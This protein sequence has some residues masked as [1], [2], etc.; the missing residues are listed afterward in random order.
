M[1]YFKANTLWCDS[2]YYLDQHTGEYKRKYMLILAIGPNGDDALAAVL[3]S[4]ANGLREDPAC[5]PGPPRA[6][7]YIGIPGSGL[8]KQ[9]WIDF[10]SVSD[11]DAFEFK[12]QVSNGRITPETLVL[13]AS[14]FCGVL[15]CLSRSEDINNRQ[16][17]WL[18]ATIDSHGCP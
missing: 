1:A 8:T 12:K 3:T 16:H 6:G 14:T 11:E 7:Y 2:Q 10:S 18:A 5:D 15:R 4:K 17:K 9:T 13:P